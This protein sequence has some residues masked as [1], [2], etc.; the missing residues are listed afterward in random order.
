[1]ENISLSM[2]QVFGWHNFFLEGR[3]QVEDEPRG[4]DIQPQKRKTM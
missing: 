2:A 3:E 4:E 1:M